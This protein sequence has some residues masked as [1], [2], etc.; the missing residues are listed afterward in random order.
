MLPY[1]PTASMRPGP[2]RTQ[3]IGQRVGGEIVS[4]STIRT[5]WLILNS[6]GLVCFQLQALAQCPQRAY[7]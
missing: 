2:F 7:P 5:F 6:I 4:R 1:M 3:S